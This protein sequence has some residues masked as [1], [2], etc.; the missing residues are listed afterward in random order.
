HQRVLRREL[1]HLHSDELPRA[2]LPR[3]VQDEIAV[4]H[5]RSRAA[6]EPHTIELA[7]CLLLVRR[8]LQ[9]WRH[10]LPHRAL[11]CD[12]EHGGDERCADEPRD[13]DTGGANHGDLTAAREL[14]EADDRT[15]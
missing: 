13:R 6:A 14:A 11:E 3:Y 4:A 1:K 8:L 5:P 2:R 10:E 9:L 7:E 15:D 12:E